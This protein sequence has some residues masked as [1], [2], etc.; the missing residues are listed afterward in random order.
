MD[1]KTKLRQT[2][3]VIDD[4]V[5]NLKI[6]RSILSEHYDIYALAFR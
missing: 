1:A 5:T 4:N 2:V 6:A 3:A